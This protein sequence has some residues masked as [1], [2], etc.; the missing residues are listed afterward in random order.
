MDEREK[1][2]AE[3]ASRLNDKVNK[4]NDA[5]KTRVFS[6]AQTAY[7]RLKEVFKSFSTTTDDTS[8]PPRFV[9]LMRTLMFQLSGSENFF[10]KRTN[11]R[12]VREHLVEIFSCPYEFKMKCW[13]VKHNIHP[14]AFSD[15]MNIETGDRILRVLKDEELKF[16]LDLIADFLEM[17]G[18]LARR[19]QSCEM[20]KI[21]RTIVTAKGKPW[22][23]ENL[24]TED[25]SRLADEI[26][27]CYE[28][29]R[30]EV[31]LLSPA[32][33]AA[34]SYPKWTLHRP[35]IIVNPT[36]PNDSTAKEKTEFSRKAALKRVKTENFLLLSFAE[37]CL[38]GKI[39]AVKETEESVARLAESYDKNNPTLD[40][41]RDE[42]NYRRLGEVLSADFRLYY[43]E[44]SEEEDFDEEEGKYIK[45]HEP[46]DVVENTKYQD[47]KERIIRTIRRI[48]NAAIKLSYDCG[49][50]A[51]DE[52]SAAQVAFER[53]DGDF[54][55]YSADD[56]DT[57]AAELESFLKSFRL[58][59]QRLWV[60]WMRYKRPDIK[61]KPIPTIPGGK[62]MKKIVEKAGSIAVSAAETAANTAPEDDPRNRVITLVRRI[63]VEIYNGKS[64]PKA[65]KYIRSS[66]EVDEKYKTEIAW[67]RD[68]AKA[69]VN[70]PSSKSKD[71]DAFWRGIETEA[72]PSAA[73]NAMK[74]KAR[75]KA[76]PAAPP[77]PVPILDNNSGGGLY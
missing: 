69:F 76:K 9:G 51:L 65:V 35:D 21:L 31:R 53:R 62:L 7:P 68:Y 57:A 73:K 66:E 61:D 64:I 5:E 23:G 3:L 39:D 75:K 50:K 28:A 74:R 46:R 54:H 72:R 1:E 25:A 38:L 34:I 58:A 6:H 63:N 15:E 60:D 17:I 70:S 49:S 77:G 20:T 47:A 48:L 45:Y 24:S 29:I 30:S 11:A 56:D 22:Y 10:N 13:S 27:Y 32:E 40:K 52:W 43:E 12:Q 2:L 71:E 42:F 26:V 14:A 33:R 19:I 18:Q 59:R 16:I 37:F 41:G 55:S 4:R 36:P 44:Y 8:E 67:A